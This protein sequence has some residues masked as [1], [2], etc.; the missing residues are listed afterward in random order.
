MHRSLP[1]LLSCAVLSGCSAPP[2]EAPAAAPSA[3]LFEGARLIADASQPPIE[4]SAFVVTGDAITA[5]G[6]KG[7]VEAP[8]GARRVDLTGKTVMPAL[9]DAHSH[10]GYTD[11]KGMTTAAANF[12]RDNLV[13]HLRRYA[14]YG[15]AATLSM[16]VDR[17]E[18][19][20]EIRAAPV[21]GAAL[22]RT[23]GRGM[24]LPNAGPGAEYR[25]DA[26]YGVSTEAEARA[27]VR[28]LAARRVD[29]VK[30]WVDDRD[31]TV[32][33][34]PPPMYRAIIDEAHTNGLRVSAHI[35]DLADAKELV[36]AGIDGFAHGVRD[37]DVDDELLALMKAHPNVWV[38]PNLP[39]RETGDDYAWLADT[40]PQAEI[41]RLRKA[42]ASRTP[43]A[44]RQAR[45]LYE[46]QARNLKR[47]S[48]A[49]AVIAY[50]TDAGVSVG[51]NALTELSDMAAAGMTPAQVL[52]AATKTSAAILKLDRLGT[53]AAGKSADFVVLDANPLDSLDNAR[54]ISR[55]YLRGQEVDRA[56]LRAA[57]TTPAPSSD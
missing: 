1:V 20:Y 47:L 15:I 37:R 6:E 12:T 14:Y 4:S 53:I 36:H 13:D 11:V 32:P 10:L 45:E 49:G 22:F 33:K 43:A 2:L 19:P 24:A 34:L 52:T 55:V 39:E 25:R 46:V 29:I 30:I 18:L 54:R 28:E 5:V 7:R 23:A 38:I 9:V 50:G 8:A 16:G 51:W 27:A 40:V 26:A 42:A 48:D 3:I 44:A 56:A 31:G 21:T 35:F 41:D 17:G 57:W